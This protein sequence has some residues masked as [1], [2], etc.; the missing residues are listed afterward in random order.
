MRNSLDCQSALAVSFASV[1]A[2]IVI[3]LAVLLV[4]CA[5]DPMVT[6]KPQHWKGKPAADLETA[7]GKPT[8]VVTASSGDQIWEYY[9]SGDLLIPKGENMSFGFA[10]IGASTGGAGAFS[11]EKR[12]EDRVS[13]EVKLFRFKVRD[14]KIRE[15]Y[16]ARTLDGRTVWEDR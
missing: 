10:G 1:K 5:S 16:A 14:G 6:G 9:Q 13:R 15:W 2:T 4:S 8:R 11:S 3:L 7:W 12:P